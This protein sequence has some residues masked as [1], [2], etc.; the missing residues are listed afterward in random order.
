MSTNYRIIRYSLFL[1]CLI[2]VTASQ[3]Q[4]TFPDSPFVTV[5]AG[6]QYGTSSMHQ[7]L[8]GNHYRKDWNT[9]VKVKTFYLDTAAGGLTPYQA[10]GGRQSKT[11][12]L[13]NPQ[14]REYVLRSIDKTFG[15]AL[16][17]I[18]QN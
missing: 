15:R 8:W 2:T 17:D 16:P 12:R 5:T 3:A 9:P 1:S 14:G 10:G 4:T 13:H 11:L 6:S 7:R 18:Y